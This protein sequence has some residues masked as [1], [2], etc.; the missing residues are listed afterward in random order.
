MSAHVHVQLIDRVLRIRFDRPEKKNA[1]TLDMY[2]AATAALRRAEEDT[3]VRC[4]LFSGS[5][6]CFTAGNDLNAFLNPSEGLPAIL[7]FLDALTRATKPLVAA[8]DGLAVGIGTT[9]LLH[10]DL[11]YC[12]TG[13]RFKLPF[14]D[15]GLVPE[16]GSSL[17][18]PQLIGDKRA[19]AMLLLG[20]PLSANDAMA[21]GLVNEVVPPGAL[22]D[23]AT[24]KA[25]AL[26]AKPPAALRASR[27][28]L[29]APQH[30]LLQATMQAEIAAFSERL[31]GPEVTEAV[32]AFLEKRKPDFSRFA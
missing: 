12:S 17:L 16:A 32:T 10:C 31:A 24:S 8:V 5:E 4:V 22:D 27:A 7:A 9:M 26:A 20:E 1:L 14:V 28:L 3:E 23:V 13:A 6:G 21:L 29:R 19:A 30:A 18:L 2:E 25:A 15:L 11:V